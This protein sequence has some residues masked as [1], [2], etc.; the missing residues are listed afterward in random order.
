MEKHVKHMALLRRMFS[1]H[2]WQHLLADHSFTLQL[3]TAG[4]TLDDVEKLSILGE[5]L[6]HSSPPPCHKG[7]TDPAKHGGPFRTISANEIESGVI[8]NEECLACGGPV[9][10][11]TIAAK[12]EP[13]PAAANR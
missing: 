13:A 7:S 5:Q 4:D 11:V 8:L 2:E 12:P 9:R 6:L 3:R 10:R 1:E